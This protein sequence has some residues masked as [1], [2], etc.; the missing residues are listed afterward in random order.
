MCSS[1]LPKGL[2]FSVNGQ[3][4]PHHSRYARL[5]RQLLD[6]EVES[7]FG[8]AGS[9]RDGVLVSTQTMEQSL[10]VDFDVLITDLCPM[11]VLL[12]RLGRL[13]R[14]RRRD[15]LRPSAHAAPTCHIL[16]PTSLDATALRAAKS[17]QYGKD[18]AYENL[19]AVIAA[20]ERL[21]AL[22]QAEVPIQVP[23]MS[24]DLVE[25]TL[26]PEVL[27][28]V[29]RRHGLTAEH[30]DFFSRQHAR[31]QNARYASLEWD[32]PFTDNA[33]VPDELIIGTRQIG[34]AHV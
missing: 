17:H 8:P 31:R 11:D 10:D 22:E 16:T 27:A 30:N 12:Q 28:E 23:E 5:D 19:F 26:H 7:R 2:L 4:C 14:H 20:W 33:G 25:N 29:A 15:P 1:D 13:H 34:R 9:G 24:R 18:R 3:V 6:A 21:A 32:K